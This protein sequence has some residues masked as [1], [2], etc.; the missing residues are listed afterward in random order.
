[1]T[2]SADGLSWGV[3][4]PVGASPRKDGAAEVLGLRKGIALR[5]DK[6]HVTADTMGAGPDRAT[7][8]GEHK[9]GSAVAYFEDGAPAL[10]RPDADSTAFT[11]DDSGRLAVD[12]TGSSYVLKVYD[13]D[14]T[15]FHNT[16]GTQHIAGSMTVSS[17]VAGAVTITVGFIPDV[18]HCMYG[19][20]VL[21]NFSVMPA[22]KDPVTVREYTTANQQDWEFTVVDT[23]D[24]SIER[25]T[26]SIT[27]SGT[28]YW[29]AL[30]F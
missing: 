16:S 25:V 8:G 18:I 13:H 6:E 3:D 4:T 27:P 10:T 23:D 20:S 28:F 22:S 12:T 15:A 5:Y 21:N 7:G 1:M 19:G 17:L 29:R 26:G 9:K 30:K 2:N 11:A 24:I 14:D